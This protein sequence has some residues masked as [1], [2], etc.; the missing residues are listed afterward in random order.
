MTFKNEQLTAIGR[1]VNFIE[2]VKIIDIEKSNLVLERFNGEKDKFPISRPA[3]YEIG[4]YVDVIFFNNGCS[5]GIKLVGHTP[6]QFYP[7]KTQ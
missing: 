1:H 4:K 2:A 3:E 6:E 5:H 7:D